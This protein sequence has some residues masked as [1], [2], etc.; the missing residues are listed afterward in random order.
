[1][2][3][4]LFSLISSNGPVDAVDKV[5]LSLEAS[6]ASWFALV[7]YAGYAV[8]VGCAMEAPETFVII[9]QWWLLTFRDEEK[10]ETK[11]DKKSWLVPLAAVGLIVIVV[12]ILIETFAEAKVSDVDALIRSHE[13]DK[14]SAAETSAASAIREAGNAKDS[15]KGAA[16][17]SDLAK[18]SAANAVNL[19]TGARKEADS[20]EQDIVSA[21][22]QAADA[23]SHLAGALERANSAEKESIRLRDILGGWQLDD[24][25]KKRFAKQVLNFPGTP[26]DLAVNP[27]E[28][29]FMEVMDTLLTSSG[30]VRQP[31]KEANGALAAILIDGKASI[32]LSSGIALEVD[33]DQTESLKPAL[34]ALGNALHDELGLKQVQLHLVPPGT[35]GDRIHIIIGKR[36]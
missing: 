10:E 29:T 21:K 27:S 24:G 7:K 35:W 8:A 23:E 28:A 1:V 9:K 13:S 11:E 4:S 33:K 31:P 36:E 3:L 20:F 15:A 22:K 19:A 34:N 17:A 16:G 6:S 5:R 14:I 26:F 2:S 18:G 30:W 32:I 25:A 12:G